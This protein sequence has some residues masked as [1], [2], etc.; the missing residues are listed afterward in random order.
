MI[1][2]TAKNAKFDTSKPARSNIIM[3][4]DENGNQVMDTLRLTGN[5]TTVK[6]FGE[7]V[8]M[9]EVEHSFGIDEI[10]EDFIWQ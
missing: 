8:S 1:I 9:L 2:T 4:L 3:I 7:T 10:N 5:M 6:E